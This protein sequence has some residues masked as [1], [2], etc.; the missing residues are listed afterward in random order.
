MKTLENKKRF[1]DIVLMK[2][3][4]VGTYVIGCF[5]LFLLAIVFCL[6]NQN[7]SHVLCLYLNSTDI[8]LTRFQNDL[9]DVCLGDFS[10]NFYKVQV[11]MQC[12]D[13]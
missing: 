12:M 10:R 5:P 11:E 9:Y 13:R 2:G 3:C 6:N 4:I 8:L 1:N 7:R